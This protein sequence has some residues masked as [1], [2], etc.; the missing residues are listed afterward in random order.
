MRE[1][2]TVYVMKNDHYKFMHINKNTHTHT[3]THP[4]S[5]TSLQTC[6]THTQDYHANATD[7]RP[8][9]ATASWRQTLIY[10]LKASWQLAFFFAF[11]ICG[12]KWRQP[13]GQNP[14]FKKSPKFTHI[15]NNLHHTSWFTSATSPNMLKNA[16]VEL[17]KVRRK[18][19]AP[20]IH[21]NVFPLEAPRSHRAQK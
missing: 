9:R 5:H 15:G 7:G 8:E 18:Y 19:I 17:S 10:L 3:S 2:T 12:R 4:R 20:T 16:P 14:D 13:G 6:T 1:K 11:K 21:G